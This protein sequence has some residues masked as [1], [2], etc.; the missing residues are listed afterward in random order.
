MKSRGWHFSWLTARTHLHLFWWLTN[1]LFIQTTFSH[2]ELNFLLSPSRSKTIPIMERKGWQWF[3]WATTMLSEVAERSICMKITGA[4][5][6]WVQ[7]FISHQ[8]G[9]LQGDICRHYYSCI[10]RNEPSCTWVASKT[11][12]F[13]KCFVLICHSCV[14]LMHHSSIG[15]L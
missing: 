4:S 13:W 5:N 8:T 11:S 10:L 7:L 2:T 9:S 1:D 3:K 6:S 15:V 14:F 12:I